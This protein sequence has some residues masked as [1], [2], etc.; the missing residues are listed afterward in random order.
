MSLTV[1]LC[2][3]AT[4]RNTPL[5]EVDWCYPVTEIERIRYRVFKDLWEKKYY[6]TS[7]GKFGGDFLV[8]PGKY[9]EREQF[10]LQYK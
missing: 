6:L 9:L 7:G 4:Q 8:Y 1:F 5:K 3:A 10:L 2:F